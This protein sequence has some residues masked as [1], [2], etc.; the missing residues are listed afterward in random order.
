MEEFKI[1]NINDQKSVLKAIRLK[2]STLQKL[3]KISTKNNIF[4][5][6]LINECINFA[7]D[8]IKLKNEKENI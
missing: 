5:N 3:E 8:N 1:P 6:K 2:F 7:L 4:I